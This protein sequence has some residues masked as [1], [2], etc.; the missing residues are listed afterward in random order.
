MHI[1]V[2]MEYLVEWVR[3]FVLVAA[4]EGGVLVHGAEAL[5]ALQAQWD[6]TGSG[7]EL[8]PAA[9]VG[10]AVMHIVVILKRPA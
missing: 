8:K 1:S 6:P 3:S 2:A 5:G 9:R 7:R 4:G 10:T